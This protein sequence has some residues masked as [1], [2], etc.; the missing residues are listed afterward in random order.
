MNQCSHLVLMLVLGELEL[1]PHNLELIVIFLAKG[2]KPSVYLLKVQFPQKHMTRTHLP[3]PD[4]DH[5]SEFKECKFREITV[6]PVLLKESINPLDN[7]V[8]LDF[9]LGVSKAL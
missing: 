2:T 8:D 1:L 5:R 3:L 7:L 9:V 4:V 6:T